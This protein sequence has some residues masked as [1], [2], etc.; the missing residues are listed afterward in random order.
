MDAFSRLAHALRR[1]T[2]LW[3]SHYIL[4]LLDDVSTRYLNEGRIKQLFSQLLF[5][6][7]ECAFKF[8][9]EVQTFELVVQSPGEIE[10]AR[11]ACAA[12]SVSYKF[13]QC[14]YVRPLS[15]DL[16]KFTKGSGDTKFFVISIPDV[17]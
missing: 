11:E 12:L 13:S 6:T 9:T 5:Q 2:S 7:D 10:Q 15:Y 17:D 16:E 1:S 14:W 4:Y 8:T 3:S